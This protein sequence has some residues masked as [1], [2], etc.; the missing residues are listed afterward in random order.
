MR[1][2]RVVLCVSLLLFLLYK[3]ER[4]GKGEAGLYYSVN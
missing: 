2:K 3:W 1:T 4:L